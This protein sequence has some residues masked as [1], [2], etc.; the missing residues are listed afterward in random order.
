MRSNIPRE[1]LQMSILLADD[2]ADNRH[3]ISTLLIANGFGNLL[4][5]DSGAEVMRLIETR[6]EI[7]LVLLD[8]EMPGMDGRQVLDSIKSRNDLQA[9][10][11][12]MVTAIDDVESVIEC[13]E[14]GAD[15]YLV[16]PVDEVLLRA[17]VHAGLERK[18]FINKEKELLDRVQVEK[19]KSESILYDVIPASV[20][21]RL[22]NGERRIAD[23]MDDVTVVFS[24]I[25]GFTELSSQVSASA[26]V[27]ILNQVFHQLDKLT[28]RFGLEKIKT[29][30]DAYLAVGGIPPR[31]DDHERRCMEFAL[32]A[33]TTLEKINHGG[34][35]PLELRIGMHTGPVVAGIIGETRYVYDVWGESVNLASRMESL[36]VPG[37]IQVTQTT[38]RRLERWYAFEP[39]GRI[40]VKGVGRAPVYLSLPR[41]RE[42]R[43]PA[44]KDI[45]RPLVNARMTAL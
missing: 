13:I 26:L 36:G 4:E 43:R 28:R 2:M 5:A 8:I 23:V 19:R 6:R 40:E 1:L 12:I 45:S 24:D 30:G 9:I 15:D 14:R 25:V 27:E 11:V 31:V 18:Y 17:R 41:G 33:M 16:K 42:V 44:S 21:D 34:S 29:I 37:R 32:E 7:D 35:T 3:A 20:A 38:H 10:P 39:R 22:R